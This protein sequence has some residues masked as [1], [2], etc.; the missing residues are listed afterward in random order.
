MAPAIVLECRDS[1][2]MEGETGYF[3]CT[4]AGNPKP[5]KL[6][7]RNENRTEKLRIEFF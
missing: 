3:E 2:A 6:L 5:G 7:K 1:R 4:M